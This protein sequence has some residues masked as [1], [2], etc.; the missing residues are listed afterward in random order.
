MIPAFRVMVFGARPETGNPAVVV[1]GAE[2]R[3][4]SM[5]APAT[6]AAV[7][8]TAF[9]WP[10]ATLNHFRIRWF[11]PATEVTLCGHATLAAARVL[12]EQKLVEGDQPIE[13]HSDTGRLIVTQEGE[14]SW[15]EL[16]VP[17][18]TEY[19]GSRNPIVEAFQIWGS[20]T[21]LKLPLELTPERDLIIPL[22]LAADLQA[23]EPQFDQLAT[24][25]RE[26]NIRGFALLSRQK[27]EA[28]SHFAL[29]F[30]APH[31]GIPED[32]ATGSVVGPLALYALQHGWA[33]PAP[34][35]KLIFEQGD[36]IGRP[37]RLEVEITG[38]PPTRLRVG[39]LTSQP[40]PHAL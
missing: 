38:N 3:V 4:E 36:A 25:G 26:L 9:V 5:Q 29:R 2:E 30:F 34:V 40:I 6:Q 13:F 21:E 32:P 14:V 19:T 1:L 28:A 24:L 37:C 10:E 7:S 11:T 22:S 35:V 18:S 31:Y 20:E 12:R 27:R 8:D 17:T 33:K 23:I 16:S 15:L 39:G